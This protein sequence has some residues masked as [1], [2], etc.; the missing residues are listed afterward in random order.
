MQRSPDALFFEEQ[1]L[2]DNRLLYVA[3]FA[4]I[5]IIAF[6]GFAIFKQVIQ[7]EPFGDRPMGDTALLIVGGLYIVLGAALL[8]LFFKGAMTT[9]VR[10]SGLY[11]RYSPFHATFKTIELKG[12]RTCEARTYGPIREF[13]GWG[14]RVGMGKRAYNV[15]G[16]QG[17]ELTYENG[18]RLLIGSKKPEQLAGA[19]ESIRGQL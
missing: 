1:P 9:E 3:F 17:V 4:G 5:G 6:F 18:K 11:V 19:V 10:P 8:W 14:I 16:N 7:G 15:S 13:G 12:L 2:R